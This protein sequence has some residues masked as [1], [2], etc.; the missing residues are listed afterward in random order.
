VH[1]LL[2]TNVLSEPLHPAPNAGILTRLRQNAP[3]LCT[4]AEVWHELLFGAR[5]LP[6]SRRRRTIESYLEV[7]RETIPILPYDTASADWQAAERA[8]L[9]AL[10]T[11]TPFADGQ[12]AAIAHTTDLVLVTANGDDFRRFTGL[13]IEDWRS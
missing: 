12:I 10:G 8:R 6:A 2:D 13:T 5:R 1:Y 7:V 4:A 11:P 9:T 3:D